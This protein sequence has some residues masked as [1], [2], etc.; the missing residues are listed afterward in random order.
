VT[1][2]LSLYPDHATD[3][4]ELLQCAA[5]ARNNASHHVAIVGSYEPGQEERSLQLIRIVGDFPE[6]LRNEELELEFQPKI[7]CRTNELVGAEALV[8]WQHP[9]LGRLPPDLFIE[10]VEQAGSIAH[11]TRYVLKKA[12][13]ECAAWRKSGVDISIAVNIS[14]DDLVDEY[15]PY[16]LL[17]VTSKHELRP[18]DVTLEVTESAI[19]HNV[20]MSLSVVSC[21]R[22]LGFCV[23]I[24]D[25][26]TGQA[27]LSQLKRLPVDEL[28][29]DKSFV[30]NMSNRRDE[31]IVRTSIELAH[32]FGLR[33]VAE[34]VETPEVLVRLRELGCEYAQGFHV[35]KPLASAA[36]LEWAAEWS[37]TSGT[38]I[39][40][41]VEQQVS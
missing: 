31:A 19:M 23:A 7:D 20:Q 41:L 30:L 21:M 32:Q 12:M 11:L 15:L 5:V 36:F 28:K 1:A 9:S 13:A 35:S 26:G 22:E 29:I 39:V 4:A 6:A 27:A 16:F 25:F 33:V 3:A 40:E 8:R 34:G 17:E 10:A 37:A 18:S 14:V 38:G 2:G 24:D